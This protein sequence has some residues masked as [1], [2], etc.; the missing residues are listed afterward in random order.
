[1]ERGAG[2]AGVGRARRWPEPD[3]DCQGAR[4]SGNNRFSLSSLGVI[5]T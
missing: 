3:V 1:M 5:T 2:N 4:C